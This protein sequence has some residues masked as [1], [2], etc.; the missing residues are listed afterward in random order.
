LTGY[1]S[2]FSGNNANDSEGGG[3]IA[4]FGT[5]GVYSSS[6]SENT[7]IGSGGG[8]GIYNNHTLT[9][10]ESTFSGNN[11]NDSEGGGGIEN[12]G[13]LTVNECTLS[14]NYANNAQDGGGGIDNHGTL[15]NVS[16][17][18]SG[19]AANYPSGGIGIG[20]GG[21]ISSVGNAMNSPT[22]TIVNS[23]VA[24]NGAM[25]GAGA[26][27]YIYNESDTAV[28]LTYGGTNIVQ[29][30]VSSN[31]VT[32]PDPI[33]AAP[34]LA[35]LGN[36][37][38][39][40]QT[41]P[42]LP[43]SPA[44][45]TGSVAANTFDT[46]QRGFPRVVNGRVDIGAVEGGYSAAGPGA[47]IGLKPEGNG[48]PTFSFT[49]YTGMSFTVLATTNLDLPLA[50]WSNLGPA[51]EIPAGSGYYQCIDPQATNHPARFYSVRSP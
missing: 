21:G 6:F 33:N 4:N 37:G 19:N 28:V 10:N 20:G 22:V 35:P 49:N 39:L 44:L 18:L 1:K 34:L 31:K 50:L 11:A 46:D 24:G 48:A 45:A 12:D 38:G 51:I 41:M 3:G 23:I 8:G 36:Y 17:T 9:V 14:G 25:A 27:I 16:S 43:G 40:T 30:L 42:P 7:A 26:D 5:L 47:L 32:G 15:T 29:S 13:S 2:A